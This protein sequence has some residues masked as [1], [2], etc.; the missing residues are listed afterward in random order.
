MFD[1]PNIALILTAFLLAGMFFFAAIFTTTVFK[2]LGRANAAA[3]LRGLFPRYYIWVAIVGL[4]AAV[5]IWPSDQVNGIILV[6][7]AIAFIAVRKLL[8]PQ[9]NIAREGR[10][11]G[12]EAASQRFSL[13]HRLSV[14]IY[15]TQMIAL[16][17]VLVC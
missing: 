7:V 16:V 14:I 1:E 9:I 10:A 8:L 17:A 12:N 4:L 15:L 6:V 2:F 3:D 5:L 11:A 13:L